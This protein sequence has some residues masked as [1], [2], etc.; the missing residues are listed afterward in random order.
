MRSATNTLATPD[1]LKRWKRTNSDF[2]TVCRKPNVRPKK[3]TLFHILN[4]CEGFLGEN[5]RYVFRHD[6]ILSY[7]T[8]TLKENKPQHIQIFADLEGHK[9]NGQTIP[10]DIMVTASRPDLVIIDSSSPLKT[11]YLFE[12]TTCFERADNLEAANKR[13]YERYS[14]LAADIEEAGYICKNIPFEV[15]SRGHL[16]MSNRSILTIL[17]KLCS[18][19]TTFK[20]FCQNISK[21]SL[22]CSYAIYLSRSDEWNN[23]PLLSPVKQSQQAI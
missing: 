3:A 1:N 14:P 12:L 15:G 23:C 7:M 13:K 9:T 20:K 8:T 11:V 2:C 4:H 17:H 16:T 5:E 21:T 19:K 6:S 18:P 22:L 10:Q